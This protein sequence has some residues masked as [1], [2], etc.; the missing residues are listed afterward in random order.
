[1]KTV[2]LSLPVDAK[3]LAALE[4]GTVV[5]LT[6]RVSTAREGVYKMAVE[7]RRPLPADIGV[8]SF[9][10]SPAAAVNPDGSFTV[11]AVTATAS[12]R[13]FLLIDPA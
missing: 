1:M 8:A 6:G 3:D 12:F 10:C 7:D 11:G 4:I 9:H 2:H 13:F 5:Y